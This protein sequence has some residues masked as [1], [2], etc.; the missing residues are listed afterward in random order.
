MKD[1]NKV[2]PE[3]LDPTKGY[4]QITFLEPYFDDY[5]IFPKMTSFDK[6]VN[7]RKFSFFKLSQHTLI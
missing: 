6:S 7:I 4:I 3:Q 2:S 1:S 5:E